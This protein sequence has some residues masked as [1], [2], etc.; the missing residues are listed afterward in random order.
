MGKKSK[1]SVS[2]NVKNK[3]SGSGISTG[4]QFRPGSKH[5]K[6]LKVIVSV[7]ER[8]GFEFVS[9]SNKVVF[10][11][12]QRKCSV[13]FSQT[14]SDKNAVRQIVRR[15]KKDLVQSCSPSFDVDEIPAELNVVRWQGI[16]KV[17][18]PTLGD[19]L[20]SL[21]L[22]DEVTLSTK[23][24]PEAKEMLKQFADQK[25]ITQGEMIEEMLQNYSRTQ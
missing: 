15:M 23:M 5:K 8:L 18:E 6:S 13:I 19:L 20:D 24:H 2:Q 10:K 12:P 25:G 16:G 3:K 4:P 11:H 9:A 7:L 21:P 14:P 1:K 22:E 17:D